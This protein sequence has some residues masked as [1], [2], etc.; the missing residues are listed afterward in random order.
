MTSDLHLLH[1]GACERFSQLL[2]NPLGHRHPAVLRRFPYLLEFLL[3]EEHLEAVTHAVGMNDSS[4]ESS[5]P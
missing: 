1:E 3:F 4:D 5:A 2:P